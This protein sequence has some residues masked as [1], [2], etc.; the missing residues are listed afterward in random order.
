MRISRS[1]IAAVF[2]AAGVGAALFA[3]PPTAQ[4]DPED[5][6][7]YCSGNQTPGDSGCRLTPTPGSSR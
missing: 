3:A 1:R 4:A 2:A 7:P 5:L 6:V